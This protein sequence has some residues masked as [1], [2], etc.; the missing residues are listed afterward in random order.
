MANTEWIIDF[1]IK[2][3]VKKIEIILKNMGCNIEESI[4]LFISALGI[5]QVTVFGPIDLP[6][7][8]QDVSS[9][10]RIEPI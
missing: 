6:E 9:F 2:E 7:K 10:K 1:D 8:L 4:I 5:I 3:N